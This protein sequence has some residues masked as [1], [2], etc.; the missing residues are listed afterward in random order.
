M[1]ISY[2]LILVVAIVSVTIIGGFSY[3]LT[4]SLRRALISQVEHNAHQLSETI[5]SGTKYDMLLNRRERV[6]RTIDTIADQDGIEKV[7]IFNK[8]G[9][10]IYSSDEA[11]VGSMVDKQTEACYACH[12]ADRP[13]ERLSVTERTRIFTGE[14]HHR[15]LGII[16]PIYND[17]SC[18]EAACHAHEAG[19][20]VLGVLDVT[21]SLAAVDR[22]FRAA[23]LRVVLFTLTAVVAISF[24]IWLLFEILVGKP[25]RRL[26]E[27][28]NVVAGGDLTSK[29]DVTRDDELGHLANSFNDMTQK[30]VEVQQQLYQSDKLASLGRLAAGVAHEINNPLTGVLTYSSFLAK[31]ISDNPE[32]KEDLDTIV[33]ETKRCRQIVR[34]LLDFSRQVPARTA[35][36]D[37]DEVITKSLG[38]VNNRL[39]FDNILVKKRIPPDLPPIKANLNQMLQ[40]F[41]NLFVNAADAIGGQGGEI[42]VTARPHGENLHRQVEIQVEDNGCGIPP[43]E[44]SKV[45]EPFY[46][47]KRHEG[48]GLGLAVVWGIV[49]KHSGTIDMV[50]KVDVG[51]TVTLRLP[52]ATGAAV[53]AEAS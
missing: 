26:V 5:K 40:V 38:I 30:L 46:T 17:A 11:A 14:D 32:M 24:I 18:S 6:H 23:R 22:E 50:S 42:T 12:T 28:T 43:E 10:I 8:E 15:R 39:S 20:K 25:V 35:N 33:R 34:G 29:L 31:R 36:V 52:A 19:Q 41:I 51:T 37:L 44:V 53:V 3:V 9:E 47:T 16:N 2:K 45:F 48:T 49:D 4:D 27:A 13:L 1:K 7:R 21:M